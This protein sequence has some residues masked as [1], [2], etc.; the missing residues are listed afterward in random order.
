MPPLQEAGYPEKEIEF[1]AVFDGGE[2]VAGASASVATDFIY[3][4]NLTRVPTDAV[5]EVGPASVDLLTGAFSLSH[6]DVS[7]PVPGYEANLEFTRVFKSTTDGKLPGYSRVLGGAWQPSS[8][9]EAEGEGEAWSRIE[10][11]VL[12]EQP[13]VW[14]YAC[15]EEK[16]VPENSEDWE[17]VEK[18]CPGNVSSN[19]PEEWCEKYLEEPAQPREEWMEV[20]DNE[21]TGVSFG[22]PAGGG[23]VA[24][25]YAKELKLTAEGGGNLLVLAFPNGTHTIFEKE[26][27][28]RVWIPKSISYQATPGSMRMVYKLHGNE[29]RLERE[30]APAPVECK[31]YESTIEPGCRT[32]D[33][34]YKEVTLKGGGGVTLL[35]AIAYWGPSG[36]PEEAKLVA[37]YEYMEVPTPSGAP[38]IVLKYEADPRLPTLGQF[39][40]YAASP[41]SNLLTSMTVPG[42]QPWSF[43]YEYKAGGYPNPGEKPTRLKS[44]SRGGM[45]TTIGYEVP[46]SGAGAPYEMGAASIAG[47]GQTDLPVD[48]TAI[49][50]PNHVP[51]EYP[52]HG[53]T[54]ATI[55]YMDAEG[56]QINVASPSPPGVTGASIATT[57]TDQKGNVVRELSPRARLMALE[58]S[59][60]ATVSHQLDS[61]SV[62]NPA[63][64]ELL[65]SWGPLHPVRLENGE[66]VQARQHTVTR[67]DDGEPALPSGT[68]PAYLPTKETVSTLV[69][70]TGA[71]LEPKVT[72]THYNW[73]FRKPTE[74]IVDPGGLHIRS[75]TL[76]NAGGQVIETRQ[77]EGVGGGTAG[78]TQTVYW[79]AGGHPQE[80][81]MG[82]K[83]YANLPCKILPAAQATGT[84]RPNLLVK[85]FPAYDY[86]DQPEVIT[87]SPAGGS[88][89]VRKTT[90]K[91]DSAGRAFETKVSGGGIA[92]A[93]TEA[94]TKTTYNSETGLPTAQEFICEEECTAFD[95]RAT[96]TTYNNLGQVTK[97]LDADGAETKTTYDAFGRPATVTDPRGT[98]TMHYDEA[99][100]VTTSLEVSG[101]GTF[102]ASY[103]AD[104]DLIRRGLPNGLTANTTYNVA[105]EPTKLTYTKESSCGSKGCTWFEETLERSAEGRILAGVGKVLAEPGSQVS[106]LYK[107]DAAGRLTEAQETPASSGLCTSRLYTFDKDSNRLT[108]T[109]RPSAIKGAACPSSGGNTQGYTYDNADR[110]IGPTYDAFGRITSLPAEF[111]GGKAGEKPLETQYFANDMVAKQTQNGVSNTFQLDS[112]GRQRQRE[113]LGGV[114][115]VEVFHY[116]GPG[117]SPSWT[118]LGSTWSRN[119][120][121]VGGELAAV[122]ESNGTTTFKLTNLHGDVVATA[123]SSPTAAALLSESRF[124]E[125]GEPETGT[126]RFGWLGGKSRRTELS[127]GVIQMGA[128]SYIPQLG[129][130]LTPDPEPGGSAN[131]YDYSN[132]DPINSGDPSGRKPYNRHKN[133]FMKGGIHI[134]SPKNHNSKSPGKMKARLFIRMGCE[135]DNCT[136]AHSPL[137][138]EP[139]IRSATVGIEEGVGS[140]HI[141]DERSLHGPNLEGPMPWAWE[142]WNKGSALSFGCTPGEEYKVTVSVEVSTGFGR[143]ESESMSASEYCGHGRY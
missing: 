85:K 67:Y 28:K 2:K 117:D 72:E 12:P 25:D 130:F 34:R 81:C 93:R 125:F 32:L 17:W 26:P 101:V 61:H 58:S 63:G 90:V 87:E 138:S 107:Y 39:Y 113:Q 103:N 43:N 47:W 71:E 97:Y 132:Q 30:V 114:A 78:D 5:E 123:S 116:D 118:A 36:N 89:E 9:L 31:D 112:T 111:A 52:P 92:L 62:Y 127:S 6:T 53:Y 88:T 104:G 73:T 13:A 69:P 94:R 86:L 59:E 48:A 82:N 129:R 46:V 119:V 91:Y 108:K 23:Y 131:A 141:I 139:R 77:P 42:E 100:G 68:P 137:H 76:Y 54:G 65:E 57:E 120:A 79:S 126:G 75:V 16:E 20:I 50:P 105:D 33:F 51:A 70:A 83:P 1:P 102:T 124:S 99:S 49:F 133:G 95:S 80:E 110:L 21:G 37:V 143:L 140:G 40:T 60:S 121:G 115:G 4:A 106:N 7:I 128:R 3:D 96:T 29:M 134:W 27:E 64:T 98:E 22:M 135:G 8:P 19:C 35:E 84:G 41:Y 136:A 24:P 56:H 18:S 45:T 10:E 66:S 74:T 15:Y 142:N 55:H 11:I 38:G 122:Q 44:V 109:T 14:G